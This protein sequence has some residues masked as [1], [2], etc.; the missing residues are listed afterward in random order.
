MNVSDELGTGKI[1]TPQLNTHWEFL[2]L[3]RHFLL[4]L[5]ML[6]FG[7]TLILKCRRDTHNYENLDGGKCSLKMRNSSSF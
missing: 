5:P 1:R 7:T 3:L 6:N 4:H 2:Q